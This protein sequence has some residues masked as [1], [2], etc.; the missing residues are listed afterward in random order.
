MRTNTL[1]TAA[2]FLLLTAGNAT[3]AKCAG[4][5]AVAAHAPA[6][7]APSARE[8]AFLDTLERRTFQFFWDVSDSTTG[9]TPDRWPTRTFAS[10]GATGFGLT[11]YPIGAERGYVT[12]RQAA[13]RALRTLRFLLHARQDTA[14]VGPIGYR[15]FFYHFLVPE[16]GERFK[17]TELSTIDTALLL[18]GALFCQSYFD[19]PEPSEAAIRSV[20]ESLY[21]RVDFAWTQVRPPTLCLGWSP[22]EGPLPYDW[23]GYNETMLYHLLALGSPAH[24]PAGNVWGG[25]AAGYKW[26]TFEGQDYLG[27]A[28]LFGYQYTHIWVDF[29]G[30]QDSTMRARGSDYF[31]NSRK[32]TLAQRAYAMRNPAGWTGYGSGLWGLTACDGPLDGPLELNGRQRE[33]HTY[34]PRGA[35]FTHVNDDGT[36]CPSAAAGSIVFA[37]EIVVST[38][39]SMRL[40]FGDGLFTKYG[41]VDA[42]NPSLPPSVRVQQGRLDPKLGWF[43]TDYLGID[44]GPILAML[45]N[46]R[47]GLVWKYMRRSPHLV[48][49]LRAAGFTGGWL[50]RAAK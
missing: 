16:T 19:R 49:G 37:P 7:Y 45:E 17:D 14:R 9:L 38:L 13:E 29:R 24:R 50:E 33:M 41:F 28:P 4:S 23:R 27:F 39:I 48:R 47:S 44:Q 32:A 18:A 6:A 30:I 15:G 36:I 40:R 10:I 46:Y 20:A 26:G 34:W 5:R 3:Q 2:L 1:R 8:T 12:R 11:A 31:I 43:D 22:E 42:L 35:S 25:Y 21:V